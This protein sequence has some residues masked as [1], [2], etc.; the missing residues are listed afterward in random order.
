VHESVIDLFLKDSFC[1]CTCAPN[2]IILQKVPD[3]EQHQIRSHSGLL[4]HWREFEGQTSLEN[5]AHLLQKVEYKKCNS[6]GL[7]LDVF[8][9]ICLTNMFCA[10]APVLVS[11]E[12]PLLEHVFVLHKMLIL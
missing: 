12:A 2:R 11:T 5:P 4:S 6:D 7:A 1:G 9:V 10:H 8:I 3:P